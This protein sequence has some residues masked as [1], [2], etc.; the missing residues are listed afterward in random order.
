MKESFFI[1]TILVI[2]IMFFYIP[3]FSAEK[4]VN[5]VW[6]NVYGMNLSDET[7]TKKLINE[8]FSKFNDMKI[9]TIFF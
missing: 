7:G 4:F 6:Y 5:A 8:H 9:N 2:M 3:I 1:K